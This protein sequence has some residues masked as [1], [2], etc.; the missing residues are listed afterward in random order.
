[1]K[2]FLAEFLGFSLL[3]SVALYLGSLHYGSPVASSDFLDAII[4]KNAILDTTP[5]PRLIFCGGSNLAFGIDSKEIES[6]IGMRVVN[7]GLNGALGLEFMLNEL[8]ASVKPN[9]IVI[10]SIEYYLGIEGDYKTKKA[11]SKNFPKA[12]AFYHQN[13]YQE[14]NLF[15]DNI[16]NGLKSNVEAITNPAEI[17]PNTTDNIYTRKAFNQYGDIVTHLDLAPSATLADRSKKTY[18]HYPGITLLNQ[19]A[20]F[21]HNHHFKVYWLYPNFPQSEYDIN[22]SVIEKYASDIS[23]ELRIPILNSPQDFV[24][25]DSLFFDTVY[26]L[27]RTG[28]K[29]RTEMIISILQKNHIGANQ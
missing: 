17:E 6:K 14:I 26:H 19:L 10:L 9:D 13:P 24:F 7:L 2:F 21:A 16:T 20:D 1:M 15:V 29:Q 12:L 22:R 11:A 5:S 3:L 28:R 27:R 25:P 23:N 8:R 4:D 18:K